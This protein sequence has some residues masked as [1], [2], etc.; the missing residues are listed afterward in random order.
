MTQASREREKPSDDLIEL[1]PVPEGPKSTSKDKD[2]T[3]G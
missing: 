1:A 2:E 3:D